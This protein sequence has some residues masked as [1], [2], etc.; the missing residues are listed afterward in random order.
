MSCAALGRRRVPR[1]APALVTATRHGGPAGAAAGLATDAGAVGERLGAG[2]S[3]D[4]A[5]GLALGLVLGCIS[6]LCLAERGLSRHT[7]AGARPAALPPCPL[8]S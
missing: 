7:R 5:V 4:F 2:V 8:A 1:T 6:G 3:W